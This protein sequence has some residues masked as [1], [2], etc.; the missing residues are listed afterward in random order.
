[1]IVFGSR[2]SRLALTQSRQVAEELKQRTGEDYEIRVIETRGDKVLDQSLPSIGG[3]G[4]FTAELEQA[5]L[6]EEID[7]AVH[8]LKDLPVED[9]P[10]LTLGAIPERVEANDVLVFRPAAEDGEGGT[11]PLLGHARIG[12]SSPRRMSSLLALRPD[13]EIADIRGNVPTRAKKVETGDYDATIL[14]A[15]GLYRLQ[16]QLPELRSCKLPLDLF[17]PAPGQGALGVQCRSQ[18]QRILQF[19]QTIH[20]PSTAAC[21]K[22]ERQL[23]FLLG[24]G[25]SMPLG[26]YVKPTADGNY[27]MLVSLFSDMQPGKGITLDL[28]DADAQNLA[29][30]ASKLCLPLLGNPLQ[31]KKLVLLRS[32]SE[33]GRLAAALALAGATVETVAVSQTLPLQPENLRDL[34]LHTIAFTSARAVDRFFEVL[35]SVALQL[36]DNCRLF[37]VGPSTRDAILHRGHKSEMPE[38]PAGGEA[39]AQLLLQQANNQ[40][41]LFPCAQERHHALESTLQAGG[42]EVKAL[43][44]YRSEALSGIEIPAGDYLVCTSPWAARSLAEQPSSTPCLALG[45]TT[46]AAMSEHGVPVAGVASSPDPQALVEL[47]SKPLV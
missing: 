46:A 30:S 12:T 14:A 33:G 32:G 1:M 2:G 19:L 11:I 26:A 15:A 27:R 16:L 7:V 6:Q 24:G 39:L 40:P 3:K 17:T 23:L 34:P 5:L 36:P 31:G 45:A 10:G 28:Q 13:L 29:R 21:V 22:A 4:L 42:V 18:D 41:V 37:A 9:P 43:P 38:V 47:I 8:S 20:H 44:V 25:C 35:A